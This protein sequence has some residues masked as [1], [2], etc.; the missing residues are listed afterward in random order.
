MLAFMSRATDR[1]REVGGP[2]LIN[3][4]RMSVFGGTSCKYEYLTATSGNR[5]Y[6]PVKVGEID[7]HALKRDRDQLWAEAVALEATG[8]SIILGEELWA[9]ARRE[10]AARVGQHAF[11]GYL[12][13]YLEE[14]TQGKVHL[15]D[16][17]TNVLEDHAFPKTDLVIKQL[18]ETMTGWG[19]QYKQQLKLGGK[20]RAG[21]EK[22]ER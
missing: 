15:H 18:K 7:L 13:D 8:I 3:Q 14:I 5:R 12:S 1:Y 11:T 10:Q 2:M 22:V 6:W 9:V 16:L 19:W 17:V 21:F 4:P 20:N